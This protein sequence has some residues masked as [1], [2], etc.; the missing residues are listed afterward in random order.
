[1]IDDL[2][3][4]VMDYFWQPLKLIITEEKLVLLNGHQLDKLTRDVP[5]TM[6]KALKQRRL[7]LLRKREVKYRQ[8]EKKR[9]VREIR[10]KMVDLQQKLNMIQSESTY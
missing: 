1:M 10:R 9:E 2:W 3:N 8:R 5:E 4:S 6:A 7:V